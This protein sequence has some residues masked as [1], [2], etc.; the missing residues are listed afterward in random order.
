[1]NDLM[2]QTFYSSDSSG[3]IN[4]IRFGDCYKMAYGL[5]LDD[6]SEDYVQYIEYIFKKCKKILNNN[7]NIDIYKTS[8]CKG[9]PLKK[10]KT[11][12]ELEELKEHF[13]NKYK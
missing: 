7:G 8:T 11:K 1:M 2:R 12:E 5:P 9:N 4:L 3:R 6:D 13:E 10:I